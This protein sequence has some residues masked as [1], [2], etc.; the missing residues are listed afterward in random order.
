M[1]YENCQNLRFYF[2]SASEVIDYS[3]L[4]ASI[5]TKTAVCGISIASQ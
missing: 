5:S 3:K 1:G 2:N 4:N